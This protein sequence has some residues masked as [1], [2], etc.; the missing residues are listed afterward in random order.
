[1]LPV[2]DLRLG[3]TAKHFAAEYRWNN[4]DYLVRYVGADEI[5]SQ[6]T[7]QVPIEFGAGLSGRLLNGKLIPALDLVKSTKHNLALHCGA[8]YLLTPEFALRGGYSDGRF[9]AGTGYVFKI[10]GRTLAIDYAFSS[11][12]A[13]EGSEHIFSFDLSF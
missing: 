4:Q 5:S 1:M 7:D 3:L 13:D 10:T 8:E 12:K 2:D 9:A 6:Q 11:D